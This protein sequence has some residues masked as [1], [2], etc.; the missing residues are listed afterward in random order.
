VTV[1]H[2]IKVVDEETARAL[3]NLPCGIVPG[4][5]IQLNGSIC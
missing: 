3:Q 2:D 1:A 5:C 4:D